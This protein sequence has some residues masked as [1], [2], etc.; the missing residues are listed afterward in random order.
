MDGPVDP[1]FFIST[2]EQR[3][4]AARVA[5]TE[6][7]AITERV[8]LGSR[9]CVLFKKGAL[10]DM[11]IKHIVMCCDRSPDLPTEFE[12]LQLAV[13]NETRDSKDQ[14]T[15]HV[16]DEECNHDDGGCGDLHLVKWLTREGSVYFFLISYENSSKRIEKGKD[17]TCLA[18]E[19]CFWIDSRPGKVLIHGYDGVSNSAAVAIAFVMWKEGRR[20]QEA[21]DLVY[22]ARPIVNLPEFLKRDLRIFDTR[23]AQARA[24]KGLRIIPKRN[25]NSQTE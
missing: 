8:F 6:P 17:D 15:K 11:G 1:R 25:N 16:H 22:A 14:H 13:N 4:L 7:Q 24:G 18:E 23:L 2:K 10:H 9:N 12:Y 20:F 3:D 5:E 19:V 21:F